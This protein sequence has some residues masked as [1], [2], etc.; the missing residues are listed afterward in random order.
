MAPW[1]LGS[2]ALA[3]YLLRA[4]DVRIRPSNARKNY[5]APAQCRPQMPA[6][7]PEPFS[8]HAPDGVVH[9]VGRARVDACPA[10]ARAFASHR[11][12]ARY[13]RIVQDTIVPAF[14]YR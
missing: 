10:W 2:L 11:Q 4:T 8:L 5:P 9:V 6:T 3:S 7:D 13:Y 1:L 14:D 12:D